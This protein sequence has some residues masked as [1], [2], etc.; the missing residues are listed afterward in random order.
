MSFR[1]LR[2]YGFDGEFIACRR[3]R[4]DNYFAAIDPDYVHPNRIRKAVGK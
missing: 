2:F 1:K 3:L 4:G